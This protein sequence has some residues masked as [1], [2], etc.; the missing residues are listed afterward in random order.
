MINGVVAIEKNKGIGY[1]NSMPWPLLTEDMKW[2]K[3]LTTNNVIIMGSN[4]WKSIGK[5]LP[6]RINIVI[7]RKNIVGAD[8]T[9]E[10]LESAILYSNLEYIDKEIY[11][12]GGQQLYD[13]SMKII[14]K[15]YITEIE[16]NYQCDKFFN[17]DYVNKFFYNDK[18]IATYN[19]PI[20]FTIKSYTKYESSRI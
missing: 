11:I 12:I 2:F 15:F 8:Y 14:E 18:T 5:K 13:S 10:N 16:E 19:S 6:N 9:F 17:M 1:N 7:S 3:L 20:K 4:T